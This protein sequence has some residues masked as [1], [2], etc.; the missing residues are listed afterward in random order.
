VCGVTTTGANVFGGV[1]SRCRLLDGAALYKHA[2]AELSCRYCCCDAKVMND[3]REREN[4][5]YHR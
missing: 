1:V 4:T 3:A 5:R 2:K